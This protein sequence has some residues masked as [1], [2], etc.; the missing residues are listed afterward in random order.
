MNL[1][2]CAHQLHLQAHFPLFLLP[3]FLLWSWSLSYWS[4]SHVFAKETSPPRHLQSLQ[5]LK[6]PQETRQRE[7]Q[8]Y[9]ESPGWVDILFVWFG[10]R[11]AGGKAQIQGAGTTGN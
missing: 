8:S 7:I 2:K 11:A 4:I 10:L 3:N 6:Y 5:A 9:F 1:G